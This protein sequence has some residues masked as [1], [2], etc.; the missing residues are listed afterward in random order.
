MTETK[1][2]QSGMRFNTGK[3]RFNL[4]P[5]DARLELAR[6]YTVGAAKYE[7]DNWLKGMSWKEMI[8]CAERHFALWQMGQARDPDTKCHHLAQ[9]A[10]NVLGLLVYELRGLGTD[11]RTK[12]PI[13]ENFNWISGPAKDLELGMS[14][15]ELEALRVKYAK[16]R[17]EHKAKL[18]AA[19]QLLKTVQ[20]IQTDLEAKVAPKPM[21]APGITIML[22]GKLGQMGGQDTEG[23]MTDCFEDSAGTEHEIRKGDLLMVFD[24]V[25]KED[26]PIF[27]AEIGGRLVRAR[28][29]NKDLN[30][31]WFE[32]R[33]KARLV[34]TVQPFDP[35]HINHF[36]M[37]N[38]GKT[39]Y[40]VQIQDRGEVLAKYTKYALDLASQ[41]KLPV[42]MD[43]AR[44]VLEKAQKDGYC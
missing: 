10:W 35:W 8:D 26:K 25:R 24:E 28:W 23:H 19:A 29:P 44:E 16:M 3:M 40:H 36:T 2:P 7:D 20:D 27:R 14:K 41:L 18:E 9:V 1:K 39:F 5:M 15:D 13:D 12:L 37:M 4:I 32:R 33:F 43:K 31:D 11:D 21:P 38:E 42:D 30:P 34:R 6:V 22:D 17:E